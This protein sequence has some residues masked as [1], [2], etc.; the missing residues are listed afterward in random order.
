MFCYKKLIKFNESFR[1]EALVR[2]KHDGEEK[3]QIDFTL[4]I[5]YWRQRPEDAIDRGEICTS[6]KNFMRRKITCYIGPLQ[7]FGV[8]AAII[9][10]LKF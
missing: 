3:F 4:K 2:C 1:L 8:V 5:M 6:K 9:R 10:L 7:S